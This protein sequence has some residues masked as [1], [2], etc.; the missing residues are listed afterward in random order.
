MGPRKA[1]CSWGSPCSTALPDATAADGAHIHKQHPESRES[2]LVPPWVCQ[3]R[4]GQSGMDG[5][6]PSDLVHSESIPELLRSGYQTP[7]RSE[8]LP[9]C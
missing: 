1:E 8:T 9:R 6:N 7:K 2:S 4:S 5:K 3:E